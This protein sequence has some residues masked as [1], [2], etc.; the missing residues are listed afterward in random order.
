ME[1]VEVRVS[2]LDDICKAI[3]EVAM[4]GVYYSSHPFTR[5]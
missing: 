2:E 1:L 5:Y 3:Y 4:E